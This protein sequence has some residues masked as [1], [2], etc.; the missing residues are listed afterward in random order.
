[1]LTLKN[2]FSFLLTAFDPCMTAEH[3][4]NR[5]KFLIH[6]WHTGIKLCNRKHLI[7][8]P[9][10]DYTQFDVTIVSEVY[11]LIIFLSCSILQL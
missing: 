5:L 11:D 9:S 1:M 2:L 7:C 10:Q 8:S 3:F 6:F 4:Y